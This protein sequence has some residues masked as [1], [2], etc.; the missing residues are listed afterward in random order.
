MVTY[1][2]DHYKRKSNFPL[3]FFVD[4]YIRLLY[5]DSF[6]FTHSDCIINMNQYYFMLMEI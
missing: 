6:S 5:L 2:D 4:V 3:S 1:F